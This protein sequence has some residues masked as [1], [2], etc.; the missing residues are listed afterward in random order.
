MQPICGG[1]IFEEGNGQQCDQDLPY[2][3]PG[4]LHYNFDD[5]VMRCS[6]N[7]QHVYGRTRCPK[8]NSIVILSKCGYVEPPKPPEPL[9]KKEKV[10]CII[11]LSIVA[12]VLIAGIL[13]LVLL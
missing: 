1:H 10:G 8:C 3:C 13:V 12:I 5:G 2:Y 7:S 4:K 9:T 11:L 6:F